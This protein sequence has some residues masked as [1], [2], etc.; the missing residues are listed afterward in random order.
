MVVLL[1]CLG[2]IGETS[3]IGVSK[4]Q[5][6]RVVRPAMG[7]QAAFTSRTQVAKSGLLLI[8]LSAWR[9]RKG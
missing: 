8:W 9:L 1:D 5:L 4:M 3:V 7:F 2:I 6:V